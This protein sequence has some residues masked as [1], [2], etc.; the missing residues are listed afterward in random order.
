M[1][2]SVLPKIVAAFICIPE[3]M[4]AVCKITHDGWMDESD[5]AFKWF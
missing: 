3:H 1:G 5:D 2:L 4:I